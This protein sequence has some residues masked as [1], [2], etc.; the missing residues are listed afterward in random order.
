MEASIDTPSTIFTQ[1]RRR[2]WFRGVRRTNQ[3]PAFLFL[4]PA[5][6]VFGVFAWYPILT[7]VIFS[8]QNVDLH[9][10]STWIGL[11]NFQRMITDPNFVISWRNSLL[12]AVLSIGIGFWVPIVVS[13]M[14]NEMR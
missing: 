8:F 11:E 6:V 9:A 12:F 13:I 14:V 1:N 10:E 7:T 5:L 2:A 3:L 4:L